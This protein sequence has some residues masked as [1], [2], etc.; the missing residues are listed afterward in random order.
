M[1]NEPMYATPYSV[2]DKT[3]THSGPHD[4]H[5][6]FQQRLYEN[7][8]SWVRTLNVCWNLG[9]V[10][11]SGPASLVASIQ[12]PACLGEHFSRHHPAFTL[13]RTSSERHAYQ[14]KPALNK[15]GI[16]RLGGRAVKRLVVGQQI[17][18]SPSET[19]PTLSLR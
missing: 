5:S 7:D 14:D 19:T 11:A 2:R 4:D 12:A 8:R 18:F 9:R 3:Q 10:A 6:F 17:Y 13:T 15:D 16:Q 1:S